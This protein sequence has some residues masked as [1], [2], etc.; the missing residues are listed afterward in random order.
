MIGVTL[1]SMP[2]SAPA[3]RQQREPL[4]LRTFQILTSLGESG[5]LTSKTHL[6]VL[7]ETMADR[8]K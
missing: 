8:D 7:L 4:L 5:H 6:D 3:K 2:S 1:V